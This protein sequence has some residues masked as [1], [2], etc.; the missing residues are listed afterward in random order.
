MLENLKSV[1]LEEKLKVIDGKAYAVIAELGQKR[2]INGCEARVENRKLLQEK[3]A[4]KEAIKAELDEINTDIIEL[5]QL[6]NELALAGYCLIDNP[7]Y[8]KVDGIRIK[9]KD[10]NYIVTGNTHADNCTHKEG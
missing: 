10:G 1:T 5:Q 3:L 2:P 7:Q 8:K 9:D 4:R 6:D